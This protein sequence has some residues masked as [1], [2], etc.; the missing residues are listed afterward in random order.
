[1]L[2]QLTRN[3]PWK[4]DLDPKPMSLV[5][6]LSPCCDFNGPTPLWSGQAVSELNNVLA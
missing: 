4:L 2:I 3:M 5:L 6:E 1:M